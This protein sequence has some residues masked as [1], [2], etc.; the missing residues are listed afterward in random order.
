MGQA[1]TKSFGAAAMVKPWNASRSLWN[2]SRVRFSVAE[3]ASDENENQAP[4]SDECLRTGQ[5]DRKSMDSKGVSWTSQ[6]VRL[7]Q[8]RVLISKVDNPR[9]VFDYINLC[10]VVE[11]ELKAG[12]GN[13]RVDVPPPPSENRFTRTFSEETMS[14]PDTDA[15]G[16]LELIIRTTEDGYN[17]GRSYIF[18]TG[19]SI[20]VAWER[21]IDQAVASAKAQTLEQQLQE[22]Y[23]HSRFAMTRA[24]MRQLYHSLPFQFS[25][26]G[27]ILF[28]FVL[29]V[30]QAE[31]LPLPD[32][33]GGMIVFWLDVAITSCYT[34][35]LLINLLSHSEDS[36]IFRDK[37][38]WFDVVIVVISI[39]SVLMDVLEQGG[40]VPIKML[41]LI[42]VVRVSRLFPHFQQMNR[43]V[44]AIGA[45]VLPMVNAF[46]ILLGEW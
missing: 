38:F 6:L 5:L 39:T 8:N 36:S 24:Q 3:V 10:E 20:A 15:R 27:L 7:T 9:H 1:S 37:H 19:Y 16:T 33:N 32:S 40:I 46:F 2:T 30:V 44:H 29:D 21:E 31:V 42:R 26:A 23:A 35:E 41:R 12:D 17:G 14:E 25:V 28:A 4:H 22:K 45:C 34:M 43:I 11:C 13:R 18:R